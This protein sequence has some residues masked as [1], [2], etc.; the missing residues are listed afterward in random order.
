MDVSVKEYFL[1]Y[2]KKALVISINK[3]GKIETEEESKFRPICL[4]DTGG[5]VLEKLLINR[6][7]HPLYSRVHMNENKFGMR[8]LSTRLW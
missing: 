6:I 2:G 7:N 1:I 8:V 3:Q 5:K 4:L